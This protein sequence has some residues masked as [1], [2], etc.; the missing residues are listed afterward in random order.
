[1][2]SLFMLPSFNCD[3]TREISAFLGLDS[4]KSSNISNSVAIQRGHNKIAA[5]AN[6]SR[7]HWMKF[8]LHAFAF[9]FLEAP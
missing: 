5:I 9:V 1:M 4:G 2:T 8:L 3:Y 7:A 6:D